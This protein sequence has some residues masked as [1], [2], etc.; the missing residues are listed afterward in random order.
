MK[1]KTRVII[2]ISIVLLV[3][4]GG[5]LAYRGIYK[6]TL[7]PDTYYTHQEA[8]WLLDRLKPEEAVTSDEEDAKGFTVEDAKQGLQQILNMSESQVEEELTAEKDSE[9]NPWSMLTGKA[10]RKVLSR[11]EF[12]QYYEN[13]IERTGTK[14]VQ[15]ETRLILEVQEAEEASEDTGCIV[16]TDCGKYTVY[17]A[18]DSRNKRMQQQILDAE[19]QLLHVYTADGQILEITEQ[20]ENVATIENI[21]IESSTDT[22]IQVFLNGYHK[23]Y[24][25]KLSGSEAIVQN[26]LADITMGTQGVTD[27]VLKSDVI[28]AKVLAVAE[29]G[30]EIEGY[31]I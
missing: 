29:N 5:W 31:G 19:N 20:Q 13:L 27:I 18:N 14:Q 11:E 6:Q 2:I 21:W 24:P 1:N 16:V 30:V 25:C 12:Q 23:S 17:G 26:S 3:M 22:E 8:K 10:N 7:G 15:I 9:Q 28:T 4:L